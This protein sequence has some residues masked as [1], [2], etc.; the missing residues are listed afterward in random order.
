MTTAATSIDPRLINMLGRK[1][2]SSNP[3]PIVVRELLQNA[4]DACIRAG[5]DPEI[6][7][8]L[9][10]VSDTP[11][12]WIVSCDDNGIG[13]TTDEIVTD[14]LCLGGKKA[15]GTNQ[16]GGF[17]IAKAAIMG[18]T[19]WKVRSLDNYLNREIL[20]NG[21]K[22]QKRSYRQGTRVTVEIQENVGAW[23]M[24]KALQM[25][26][27]SDV[28]VDLH[29]NAKVGWPTLTLHDPEAGFPKQDRKVLENS[30][31]F[32]MWAIGDIDVPDAAQYNSLNET[33]WNV[34]RLNGLAQ[35]MTGSRLDYRK[36]NLFFD[37]KTDRNPEDNMY[38]FSMSREKLQGIY[39]KLVDSFVQA[40]NSNVVE[41][42]ITLVQETPESEKITILPGKLLQGGRNTT[43]DRRKSKSKTGMGNKTGTKIEI[44]V[45]EQ[46]QNYYDEDVP[47]RVLLRRYKKDP[48][49]RKWHAKVL[50][51]WQDVV[52]IVAE[53]S[54]EFG[55]G[56]T[57]DPFKEATRTVLEGDTYYVINPE[58]AITDELLKKPDEA[59]VLYLWNLA[60]HEAT[61]KYVDDH[62]EWF[63]ITEGAIQRDT[64]DLILACLP[65]IAKRL[66]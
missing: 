59:I 40:H 16:T 44:E 9:T 43:Y 15:D 29:V 24:R 55:I 12:R 49:K 6:R 4:R 18:C 38:P 46:E 32:E 39:E 17:G 5:V 41:S 50:L 27:Y 66:S 23:A 13:M 25:I 61:H 45:E 7:I 53:V 14:F 19:N 21:G 62:N 20:E 26:Y 64:C 11:D 31:F 52:G 2:Y 65:R 28:T 8:A 33:G 34:V 35:F 57:S 51:A 42:H 36:T 37:I 63:T 60:C 47:V 3:L 54:E 30:E 58:E 56:I 1:L 22:I 10:K 48:N